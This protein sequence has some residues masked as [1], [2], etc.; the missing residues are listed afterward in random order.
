MFCCKNTKQAWGDRWGIPYHWNE[1]MPNGDIWVHDYKIYRMT[2]NKNVG[3]VRGK[4]NNVRKINNRGMTRASGNSS[5][6]QLNIS[7]FGPTGILD[8]FDTMGFSV[9]LQNT[10]SKQEM[11]IP[12]SSD[13]VDQYSFIDW[14][15][16][17]V[18][19]LVLKG[20]DLQDNC[21]YACGLYAI[22]D[23]NEMHSISNVFAFTTQQAGCPDDKHPHAID[24]GLP[25]GTKWACC[26][27]GAS[28][29]EYFGGYYAWGETEEKDSYTWGN[30][31]HSNFSSGIYDICDKGIEGTSYDVAHVKLGGSWKMPNKNQVD[32]LWMS[33]LTWT[34][35]Q[36]NEIYGYRITGNNGNSIFLPAA[37]AKS[38][39]SYIDIGTHGRYWSSSRDY[40]YSYSCS[41][42]W[43]NWRQFG[44]DSASMFDGLTVRAVCP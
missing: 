30:Y 29:P 18:C 1:K 31:K 36:E 26:N 43:F 27:V 11:S 7:V 17:T 25:S 44:N 21:R 34:L 39:S 32:E 4:I 40:N 19:E 9:R 2:D 3:Y 24:L 8:D 41:Y 12:I 15:D 28:K 20:V 22:D 14:G 6:Y 10:E 37:G 35:T 5:D 38:Y 16:V 23:N 13:K 42:L 33:G